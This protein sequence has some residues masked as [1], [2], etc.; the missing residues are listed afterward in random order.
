MA[1]PEPLF[2]LA[3][4]ASLKAGAHG[5]GFIRLGSVC[6]CVRAMD[7]AVKTLLPDLCLKG[8]KLA[9]VV[10]NVTA[11]VTSWSDDHRF[12]SLTNAIRRSAYVKLG[13]ARF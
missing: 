13:L 7:Y 1:S 12:T 9:E 11:V 2:N 8:L 3:S 10:E 6:V 5:V 4:T